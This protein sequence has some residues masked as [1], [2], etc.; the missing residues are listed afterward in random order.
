MRP[1]ELIKTEPLPYC[2]SAHS[3]GLI[4]LNKACEDKKKVT[5]IMLTQLCLLLCNHGFTEEWLQNWDNLTQ[6]DLILKLIKEIQLS[7]KVALCKYAAHTKGTE[8]IIIGNRRPDETDK[9]DAHYWNYW[10]LKTVW[11]K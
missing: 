1:T 4:V 11:L 3:A 7:H 6:K 8:E 9:V 2:I 10:R 5:I